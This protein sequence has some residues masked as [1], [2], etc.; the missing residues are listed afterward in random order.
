MPTVKIGRRVILDRVLAR[1]PLSMRNCISH[2]TKAEMLGTRT[3]LALTS[4]ADHVTRTILIRAQERSASHNPLGLIG[5][6]RI[7]RGSRPMWIVCHAASRNKLSVVVRTIPVAYPLP[8]VS[9]H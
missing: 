7:K 4:G 8:D 3:D 6:V 5:L 1:V 9:S 2:T